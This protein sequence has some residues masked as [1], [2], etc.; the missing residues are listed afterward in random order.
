MGGILAR[1]GARVLQRRSLT[2]PSHWPAR[3][4]AAWPPIWPVTEQPMTCLS[5]VPSDRRRVDGQP[6]SIT[7]SI[8]ATT[9]GR[10]AETVT[11]CP[12]VFRLCRRSPIVAPSTRDRYGPEP[13]ISSSAS[14]AA[15][16]SGVRHC[17]GRS[18]SPIR[19][20]RCRVTP[21]R[22]TAGAADQTGGMID[23]Q[24]PADPAPPSDS[25]PSDAGDHPCLK[26][27][28][29]SVDMSWSAAKPFSRP[30]PDF[31]MPP[32][33]SSMPPPAPKLLM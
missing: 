27:V 26:I 23:A 22:T 11:R 33:G 4:R 2:H 25:T 16:P 1:Y 5:R 24:H 12:T 28:V 31:F 14:R 21:S 17:F 30:W 6:K 13:P 10:L 29:R 20:S 15:R 9:W 32:K 3:S 19:R 18:A 7:A 8:I